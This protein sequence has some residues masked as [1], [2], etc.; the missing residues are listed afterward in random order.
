[1]EFKLGL[2]RQVWQPPTS[3]AIASTN[4]EAT[5]MALTLSRK[6][7]DPEAS[8]LESML[9]ELQLGEFIYEQPAVG[10]LEYTFKHALT[11]DVA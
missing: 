8:D 1:M 11:H 10:D 9:S 3:S 5:T 7:A 2:V 6:E 4:P